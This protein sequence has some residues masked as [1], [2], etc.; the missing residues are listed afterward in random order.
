MDR[1]KG[2]IEGVLNNPLQLLDNSD[3]SNKLKAT[4]GVS[5]K[6]NMCLVITFTSLFRTTNVVCNGLH[7]SVIMLYKLRDVKTAFHVLLITP[8]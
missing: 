5:E 2:F 7:C 1:N 3:W 4:T 8:I 6:P